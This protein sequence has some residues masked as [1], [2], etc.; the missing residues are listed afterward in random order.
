MSR[1]YCA[2]TCCLT[3][4]SNQSWANNPSE[5][6]EH[7]LLSHLISYEAVHRQWNSRE[8][9]K[10]CWFYTRRPTHRP[11]LSQRTIN[12]TCQHR[13]TRPSSI[14]VCLTP[15]FANTDCSPNETCS[16]EHQGTVYI[17][18]RLIFVHVGYKVLSSKESRVSL[19]YSQDTGIYLEWN[20]INILTPSPLRYILILFCSVLHALSL[21]FLLLG[22]RWFFPEI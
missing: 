20:P 8:R 18:K 19:Q 7:P 9:R 17:E 4:V 12:T 3:P 11:V 5:Q 16:P 10:Y 1:C 6:C 13:V 15:T 14:A 2:L 22:S 21:N